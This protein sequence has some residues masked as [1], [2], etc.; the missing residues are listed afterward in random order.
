MNEPSTRTSPET[1]TVEDL[2]R[3]VGLPPPD[4]EFV[5]RV[6]AGA[7]GA[8]AAIRRTVSRSLFDDEPGAFVA[9]LERQARDAP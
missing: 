3:V 7:A 2:A 6:I 1:A 4:A 8:V 5:G 9:E